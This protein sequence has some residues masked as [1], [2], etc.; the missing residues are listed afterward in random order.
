MRPEHWLYTIPVRLR[1]LFRWKTDQE[2]DDELR[3]HLER[4][5]G[6]YVAQGMTQEEAHRRARLDLG[7]IEQTKEKCRDARRVNWIQD[8]VQDLR[9]GVRTLRKSPGFTAVAILTL[10]LG[11]GANSAIFSV[12]QAV[13]LRPLPYQN[14]ERLI[15]LTDSQD[16]ANGAFLF[17]DIV[18]FKSVSRSFE[19]IAAYYRDSGFSRVILK[20]GGEPEF[21]QGAFV[22]GNL[23]PVMGVE[24]ALGRVFSPWEETQRERVV[25]LSHRLWVRTFSGSVDAI[26][27]TIE[28]DGV[29]SEVIGVMPASFEFPA[30]DQEFW[31]PLRTN[32]YWNDPAL[33]N[34]DPRHNRYFYE[35]WQ[36][37]GRLKTGVTIAEAQTEIN[38]LF[39]RS[40]LPLGGNGASGITLNP[41]RVTLGRNTRL[42]LLVLFCAVTLVLLISCTNVANLVLARGAAR[43]R[44]IAV[45]SALGAGRVRLTRQLLTESA[46]L[47]LLAGISG[48]AIARFGLRTLIA[49]GPPDIP[50]LDQATI[51]W[52]TLSFTL[53]ISLLATGIFG[54][55]PAWKASRTDPGIALRT[56]IRS[57]GPSLTRTRAVLVIAE[58]ATAVVLLVAAGLLV[59]SFLALENVDLGFEP[60]SELTM[61][62]ALPS[63]TPDARNAF[64]DAVL[65]RVRALPGIAAAGE[66][67]AL[68]EL[69]GVGNLGLRAI[70]G[71]PPEPKEHW[72]PLSW[73]SIRGD[74]FQAMG[75]PLVRGR[76]FTA[77][78]GPNSPL[79]AIIDEAMARRYWANK[80]PL[81]KRFKGQDPRGHNDDWLTVVGVVRNMRRSGPETAPTPHVFEPYTQALDGDRTG[82]LVVR[83]TKN[84]QAVAASLRQA[85]RELSG[86]AILS[87]VLTMED[88]LAEQLSPR[89]FQT[90]LLA[91]FSGIAVILAGAGI[92]GVMHYSVAQ[93]TQEIGIRGALGAKP[94]DV[95]RLVLSQALRLGLIGIAIGVC[96]GL[97]LTR[98]MASLLF[99]I[100]PTDFVT[101]TAVAGLLGLVSLLAS[102]IPARRAMKV[103]PM[104]ALRYE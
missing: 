14:P 37:I 16:A 78:D 35:R 45:R 2:L 44:E 62:I 15:L 43:A 100:R 13:S 25:V 49:F 7:G 82:D 84:S 53:V 80:N 60:S 34:I 81:G 70:D 64:Y 87:S 69:G 104:V 95:L 103:D 47:G 39:G 57:G 76:Y 101:F 74:Y 42:A 17:G 96:V 92:F 102:Y 4:K 91:L 5:T 86:T 10:A 11:I 65:E 71:R 29:P 51:D 30:R 8:F 63:G 9:Y 26:G 99:G 52:G 24:P 22:S 46:L 21:V 38:A 23:F 88:Q 85:V 98:L 73:A 77:Q 90:S 12:M 20:N 75:A 67:D 56:G 68:F 89:K 79:V 40:E 83:T 72:T 66:V 59:R 97:A 55:L 6:E 3:D 61:N 27:K 93:R 50:R 32:R 36:A 41:L 18:G 48:L 31:A 1:S 94:R 28:V 33:T 19:D 54:I 58:F